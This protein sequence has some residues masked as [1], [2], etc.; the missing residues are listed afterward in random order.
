LAA[1]VPDLWRETPAIC[2]AGALDF[3]PDSFFA[4]KQGWSLAKKCWQPA[5]DFVLCAFTDL[6]LTF[7]GTT[8]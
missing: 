5:G 2:P 4:A 6:F 8:S 3:Q 1:G 7:Y